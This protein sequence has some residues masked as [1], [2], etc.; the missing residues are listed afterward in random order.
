MKQ[1]QKLVI[2]KDLTRKIR[3]KGRMDAENRWRVSELLAADCEKRGFTQDG[4]YY[5]EMVLLAGRREELG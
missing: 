2:M 4:R 5:A 1:Q 3:S